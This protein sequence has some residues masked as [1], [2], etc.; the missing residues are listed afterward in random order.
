MNEKVITFQKRFAE[1]ASDCQRLCFMSRA[2][3]LQ[4]EARDKLNELYDEAHALKLDLV[5]QEDEDAANA[6]LSFEEIITALCDELNM[7][8]ALKE[9]EPDTAWN[10]LVGAQVSARTALQVHSVGEHLIGYIQHLEILEHVLFPPQKFFS[11]GMIVKKAECSI[12]GE[13]YGECDHIKGRAYMGEQ[14]VR[15]ITEAELLESSIVD[16]PANKRCRIIS[17]SDGGVMRDFLTWRVI[18]RDSE[19]AAETSEQIAS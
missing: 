10:Y 12:C 6:M 2:K 16:K 17:F 8:I 3:E 7:W 15:N 9:D 14:C 1:I 19:K 11:V 18:P 5:S 4:A 13:E